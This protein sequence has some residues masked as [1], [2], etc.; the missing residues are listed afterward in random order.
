MGQLESF[1]AEKDMPGAPSPKD[2]TRCAALVSNP[3]ELPL[4]KEDGLFERIVLELGGTAELRY[5]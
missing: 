1:F 3:R 4:W 2:G 5:M